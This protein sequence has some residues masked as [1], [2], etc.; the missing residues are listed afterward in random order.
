MKSGYMAFDG[1]GQPL[2]F[3]GLSQASAAAE[4]H[5][6]EHG[7]FAIAITPDE[8]DRP[9]PQ[10]NPPREIEEWPEQA[11]N[12]S[13]LRE[14]CLG[15]YE[16]DHLDM[17]I[18]ESLTLDEAYRLCR[19]HFAPVKKYNKLK[20]L[21]GTPGKDLGRA[22]SFGLLGRNAKLA[23]DKS[24]DGR[25]SIAF[26]LTLSPHQVGL[27]LPG[28][29]SGKGWVAPK[30][31][32]SLDSGS[33]LFSGTTR[34]NREALSRLVPEA[35]FASASY[36]T[37]ASSTQQC[38]ATCL[39][40]SGQNAASLEALQS[41][42]T[43]TRA[44]YAEPAA[45]C[46]LL[47]ENVR[48]FFSWG[49]AGDVDLYVRL[50]VFSD[51][52]WEFLWPDLFDPYKKVALRE[53]DG[54]QHLTEPTVPW[55][56]RLITGR[57]SFY[58]Y[59]KIPARSKVYA[60]AL[61]A[62]IRRAPDQVYRDVRAFYHLTFS[63]SGTSTNLRQCVWHLRQND[64]VAVVFIQPGGNLR[65]QKFNLYRIEFEDG[66]FAGLPVINADNND[67]RAKDH[68]VQ[69]DRVEKTPEHQPRIG[70][71]PALVGLAFKVAKIRYAIDSWQIVSRVY[72]P[73]KARKDGKKPKPV[74]K[75]LQVY[76][77]F[78]S[79]EEAQEAFQR[80]SF[81]P[82][83]QGKP[84]F[85]RREGRMRE[86]KPDLAKNAFVVPAVEEGGVY[87]TAQVPLQTMK[88]YTDPE[89]AAKAEAA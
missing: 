29:S 23:K 88:G 40:H 27:R 80:G 6:E 55:S 52:P 74:V 46:R 21:L 7:G 51:I 58:D 31:F 60:E 18:V 15:K 49:G 45:F 13:G 20:G 35:S 11:Y 4:A 16:Q 53:P 69:D 9:E 25:V 81:P 59:T 84:A 3:G 1:S 72:G 38:R 26:G 44:L 63:F 36:T 28:E 37:C 24:P 47:L 39:M 85:V 89:A 8:S 30:N 78:G 17:E 68:L 77:T 76:K 57:G 64:K 5:A 83:D 19:P 79:E 82:D 71:S 34:T 12:M 43:L 2:L 65:K 41:K 32:G 50:N 87:L 66:P 33:S 86:E 22:T 67:L 54:D 48:R 70:T 10:Q 73:G 62:R 75:K 42:L 56:K 61:A 14:I